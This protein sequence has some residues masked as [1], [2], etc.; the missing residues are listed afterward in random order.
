MTPTRIL[1]PPLAVLVAVV[2]AAPAHATLRVRS[3]GAGLLVQ[4][5]NGIADR[6]EISTTTL[7]GRTAYRIRNLNEND[8]FKFDR[9]EGCQRVDDTTSACQRSG[10][11]INILLGDGSDRFD[12]RNAPVGQA[13][14]STGSGFDIVRGHAGRDNLDGAGGS[15]DL[16][17]EAGNDSLDGGIGDDRLEGDAG[18]DTLDGDEG[19]D[20][21]D[22]GLGT[23]TIS[24]DEGNDTVFAR[25][26]SGTAAADVVSCG[27]GTDFAELDLKDFFSASCEERDIAPVGETPNVDILGKALPVARSGR[28]RVRLRCP[29]G[30]HALG[31]NGT[32]RLKVAGGGRTRKVSYRIKAARRKAV[33][34]K[35]PPK[36]VRRLGRGKARRGVLTSREKGRIGPK[37]TV[38]NPKLR[39]R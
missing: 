18:N 4:D 37:T 9:Q 6:A 27:A 11:A 23:D 22:G 5:K 7:D 29:R 32:L 25:E 3:D 8:I 17:G 26:Q 31:C 15:D 20:T 10:S 33:R 38:R 35:L 36:V 19:A 30:V 28:T 24:A 16:F 34:L 12:M 13:S 39:V 2:A 14:I 21:I 1:V